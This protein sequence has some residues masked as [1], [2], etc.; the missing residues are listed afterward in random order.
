MNT[1]INGKLVEVCGDDADAVIQ[2][3]L[4]LDW[5]ESIDPGFEV[6]RIEVQSVDY[7]SQGN[8]YLSNN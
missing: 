7:D 6:S 8:P 4:F 1:L 2:S 3:K 5:K